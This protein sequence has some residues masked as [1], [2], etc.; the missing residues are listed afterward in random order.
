[1]ATSPPIAFPEHPLSIVR[2]T[3]TDPNDD[4]GSNSW[5]TESDSHAS[6][7]DAGRK[8]SRE[9]HISEQQQDIDHVLRLARVKPE[10][11]IIFH[12]L[13][14]SSPLFDSE[15]SGLFQV[16]HSFMRPP[17]DNHGLHADNHFAVTFLSKFDKLK[18]PEAKIDVGAFRTACDFIAKHFKNPRKDAYSRASRRWPK[19]LLVDVVDSRYGHVLRPY[20]FREL[21]QQSYEKA[22]K[23]WGVY[24]EDV[25]ACAPSYINW[26]RATRNLA[27][28][29]EFVAELWLMSHDL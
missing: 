18:S 20:M 2:C 10:P 26:S 29:A 28:A 24:R 25:D 14:P 15:T 6:D 17:P 12:A 19:Y 3:E 21:D 23:A 27:I 7:H 8:T 16:Y 22:D 11:E 1:L 13:I 5:L 9:D 4:T